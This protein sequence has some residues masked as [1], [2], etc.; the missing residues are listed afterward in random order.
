[1]SITEIV[2]L[3]LLAITLGCVILIFTKLSAKQNNSE[4]IKELQNSSKQLSELYNQLNNIIL[5]TIKNSN[6]TVVSTIAQNHGLQFQQLTEILSRINVMLT[7]SEQ[8][9]KQATS[10]IENGLYRI[11]EN[12]DKKLE[13]MRQT[14]DEKLNA[15]LENRLTQSFSV[16]NKQLESVFA[17]VGEMR[18]LAVGVGDL[19]KVLTNVKSRGMW[20]EIQLNNLLEQ[21]L[22]HEQFASQIAMK[23]NADRVDF[24]VILPGK[25]EQQM[26]LPID[27][28]FPIEDYQR[29]CDAS[30]RGSKEEVDLAIKGLERRIKD[31]AKSIKEKYIN[32]PRTTDFAVMYLS[33][34]GLYA[35]ALR[36]PGLAEQLQQDYKVILCGPTTLSALLNSLQVGFKTLSIEKRSSEVWQLLGVFKQ[37]FSKF[38]ELLTKTQKKLTEASNT[39]KSATM[40]SRTI[41]RKLKNVSSLKSNID[42]GLQEIE[43]DLNSTEEPADD[44]ISEENDE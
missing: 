31:E 13:Q 44:K 9:M 38:V 32:V 7:T 28:K 26:Y 30:E 21:I 23:D 27:A 33:L 5:G 35:E 17:G 34:E 42:E 15:S 24:A 11:Q 2:I 22:T 40:K 3:L 29:L 1:M 19:K 37:E 20:G 14:V 41:E 39:I 4:V 36:I 18:Q 6:E 8:S 12:N 10:Q 43:E 25:D 16:I